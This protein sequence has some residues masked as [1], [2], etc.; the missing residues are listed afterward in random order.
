MRSGNRPT[1]VDVARA[2]RVSPTTVSYVRSG[3][4][5]RA[6]RISDATR[7]RVLAAVEEIGYVPNQSARNLRLQ[8]TNRVLFLG[9]RFTSLFSQMIAQSIE[10]V[11]ERNGYALEV[12]IGG[13]REQIRRAI[14]SLDQHVVD[15]LIV[16][17]DDDAVDDLREAA[18]RGHAI[19]AVGP[20]EPEALFDVIHN[21]GSTAIAASIALLVDRGYRNFLLLTLRHREPWE[22]RIALAYDALRAAGI[23]SASIVIKTCPHDRILA[24]DL[25]LEL[26]PTFPAPVAVFAGSDLSAIGVIWAATRLGL[27]LPQEVAVVGYGNTPETNITVPRLTS[28]GPVGGDFSAAADLILSRLAHPR[29]PGRHRAEPHRLSIRES[30]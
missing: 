1:I 26:L 28:I 30:T 14:V 27:R 10:P 19:V 17:T 11:L 15:G 22:P 6:N 24:H 18:E 25:A 2:A 13:G 9:G 12:R 20:S 7:A 5:T 23:P 4:R 16:E 8:R 29:T 21:D 3:T